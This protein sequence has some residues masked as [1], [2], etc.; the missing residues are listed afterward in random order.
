MLAIEGNGSQL[1][2]SDYARLVAEAVSKNK[3][4]VVRM[5]L[6]RVVD[7]W[8]DGASVNKLLSTAAQAKTPELFEL[9]LSDFTQRSTLPPI[10]EW[11]DAYSA[12]VY[13]KNREHIM[14][15]LLA[16]GMNVNGID[17]S[18]ARLGTNGEAMWRPLCCLNHPGSVRLLL[19]AGADPNIDQDDK[20][21]PLACV[22]DNYDSLNRSQ[23]SSQEQ[24]D[25]RME[26]FQLLFEYGADPRRAGGGSALHGALR[27]QDFCSATL[28]A[29]K[30]ARIRVAELTA[31][32]QE[33]LD[34]AVVEHE[35][36]TVMR[37]TPPKWSFVGYIRPGEF[38]RGRRMM[39]FMS[40]RGD[41][42]PWSISENRVV[43]ESE[44][45]LPSYV[46]QTAGG[47]ST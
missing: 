14:R 11:D 40:E 10:A 37:L 31:P 9:L 44:T 18:R 25:R 36:E 38:R 46:R 23:I 35:W 24:R 42:P 4:R 5:L 17:A 2:E 16:A 39:R 30:G 6:S 1:R 41:V 12:L 8:C 33:N 32:E 29:D 26:L 45:P 47:C 7:P 3:T 22:V 20:W 21:G 15:L 19:G 43:N 28:L 13:G 27:D 34:H